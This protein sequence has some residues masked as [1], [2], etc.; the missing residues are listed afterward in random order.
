[1]GDRR[2]KDEIDSDDD[3][4]G[5]DGDEVSRNYHSVNICHPTDKIIHNKNVKITVSN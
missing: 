4:D 3:D 1:M 2:H 5:K